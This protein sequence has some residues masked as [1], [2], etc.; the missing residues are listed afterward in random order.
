MIQSVAALKRRPVPDSIS[1]PSVGTE[2]EIAARA[3]AEKSLKSLRLT[4]TN[5]GPY[6]HSIPEL[7]KWGYLTAIP[8]LPGGDE[9]S[10]EGKLAKCERCGDPFMVKSNPNPTECLHHWGRPYGRQVDG[11]S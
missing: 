6:I 1:H 2:D 9:P 10:I 5:L 3:D 7:E 11:E 8:D 4:R